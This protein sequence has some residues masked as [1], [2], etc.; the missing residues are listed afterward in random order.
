[1]YVYSIGSNDTIPSVAKDW[2]RSPDTVKWAS[3]GEYLVVTSDDKGRSRL[4]YSSGRRKERTS[5]R[6]IS[7]TVALRLLITTA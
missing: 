1:M 4:L 7:Q 3:N 6:E 5:T 2:D